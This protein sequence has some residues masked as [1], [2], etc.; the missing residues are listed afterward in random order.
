MENSGQL[1]EAVGELW[2]VRHQELL[3]TL[4]TQLVAE[5]RN[6]LNNNKKQ[7]QN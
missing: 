2:Q 5:A 1:D 7:Q 6:K 3:L 4:A